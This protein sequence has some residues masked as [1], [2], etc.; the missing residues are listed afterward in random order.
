MLVAMVHYHLS[1]GGVTQVIANHL[2]GLAAADAGGRDLRVVIL[3]GGRTAGWADPVPGVSSLD[4]S[5]QVVPGLDYEDRLLDPG[6]LYSALQ[7]VLRRVGGSP[8]SSVLHVHNHSL[9]KNRMLP[10]ALNRLARDGWPLLLQIHDFAEDFRPEQYQRISARAGDGSATEEV[11][12]VYPTAAHVHYAV[13]NQR[14]AQVLLT[15]GMDSARLHV[16]PNAVGDPGTLPARQPVRRELARRFGIPEGRSLLLYPVRGIR[17]KNLGEALLWSAFSEGRWHVG[18]TLAPVT[19]AELPSYQ[20]WKRLAASLSLPMAFEIGEH[21]GLTYAD[22]LAAADQMLTTSVAEGFGLVFLEAW[23]AGKALV[24]RDLPEITTDFVAEG[25][26]L[27]DLRPRL[28]IPMEWIGV[29][30][31][32]REFEEAYQRTLAQFGCRPPPAAELRDVLD[33][34][35]ADGCVDFAMLSSEQQQQIVRQVAECGER[36]QQ[37]RAKNEW[38]QVAARSEDATADL[39]TQNAAVVRSRYSLAACGHRLAALYREVVASSRT[40]DVRPL[41]GGARIMDDFLRP[42]RFHP[43]R[44]E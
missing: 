37:L 25:M 24:G 3:H 7:A 33:R 17:R 41:A 28:A 44:V 32:Q 27:D 6:C 13:L 22:H 4:C 38:I 21:S 19:P 23:L 9:G 15:A 40:D 10:G 42:E 16:L 29:D 8:D 5:L 34:W 35:T 31:C 1:H 14:D 36:R 11:A 2:R 43:V 30:R 26:R 39:V 12:S 18:L 20:R